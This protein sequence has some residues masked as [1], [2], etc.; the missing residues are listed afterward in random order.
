L[1]ESRHAFVRAYRRATA[2]LAHAWKNAEGEDAA[3]ALFGLEKAAYEV[4]YE[5][6][7]RPTWLPV[8]LHGLYGLLNGLK[9]FSDT[10]TSG[11]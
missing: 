7:N 1:R 3:L 11:E 6:E 2:S 5:A 4:V 8:P 10:E 9:P